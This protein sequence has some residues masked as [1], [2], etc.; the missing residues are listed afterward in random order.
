MLWVHSDIFVDTVWYLSVAFFPLPF[1]YKSLFNY[2]TFCYFVNY[3]NP[4]N[5]R[6]TC[7]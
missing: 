7:T 3:R 2:R 6:E 5:C 1:F 4:E